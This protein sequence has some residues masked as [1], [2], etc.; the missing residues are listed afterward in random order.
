MTQPWWIPL[1]HAT[2]PVV[3]LGSGSGAHSATLARAGLSVVA[4]DRESLLA[5]SA[6]DRGVPAVVADGQ[7]LPF[8]PGSFGGAACL[9]VL[10]HVPSPD[11][12]LSEL[13]R[14]LAPHATLLLAVPTEY[15]ERFLW[16]ANPRYASSATHVRIFSKDKLAGT[17]GAAGWR[18]EAVETRNLAPAI[19]W[20]FHGVLRT[21]AD[22]TG[23]VSRLAWL[24]PAVAAALAGLRRLPGGSR[25]LDRAERHF[26]K[27]WYVHAR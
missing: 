21:P 2:L 1:A 13:R 24:E 3:D 25:L 9:E 10:E 19:A 15:T 17:L 11:L 26:G 27:S 8:R 6:R 23:A 5:A 4:V 18:I 12:I 16:W 7:A 20:L 14:T 22:H